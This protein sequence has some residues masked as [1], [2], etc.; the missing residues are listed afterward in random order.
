MESF[1]GKF[2]FFKWGPSGRR[3]VPLCRACP[4]PVLVFSS[5]RA[6]GAPA[7]GLSSSAPSSDAT[8]VRPS[9]TDTAPRAVSTPEAPGEQSLRSLWTRRLV[10][11]PLSR[12]QAFHARDRPAR[13]P[14]E[15]SPVPVAP[16]RGARSLLRAGVLMEA[17]LRSVFFRPLPSSVFPAIAPC[18]LSGFLG[19]ARPVTSGEGSHVFAD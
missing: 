19:P 16:S 11:R 6:S 5:N 8:V 2:F 1:G 17:L 10:G 4:S 18:F 12:R 9:S 7:A 13:C 14:A 15:H 3:L